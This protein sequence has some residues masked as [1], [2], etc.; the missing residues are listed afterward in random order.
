MADLRGM[1]TMAMYKKTI[2]A[3]PLVLESIYPAPNPMDPRQVRSEKQKLSFG[4]HPGSVGQDG[5]VFR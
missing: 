2:V 1:Q 3:G 4:T 5:K